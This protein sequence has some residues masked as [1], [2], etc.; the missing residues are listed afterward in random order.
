MAY[1]ETTYGSSKR[2][3]EGMAYNYNSP[4]LN[5]AMHW[6][7]TQPQVLQVP[8]WSSVAQ[9]PTVPPLR[10]E[11]CLLT[12]TQQPQEALVTI[13]GKEKARKPLDPP[14]IVKLE[15]LNRQDP[16][17]QFFTNPYIFSVVT[18]LK[19]DKNEPWGETGDKSLLGC[20]CSSLHRLKDLHN[21]EGGFFIWGDISLRM[22]G[23]FRLRFT[24]YE[25]QFGNDTAFQSLGSVDSDIFN[26]VASKDFRGLEE[27]TALTRSF[28]DQGV[29]LRLRKETKGLGKRHREESP[30]AAPY[31]KKR[32][33]SPPAGPSAYGA[34]HASIERYQAPDRNAT[35]LMPMAYPTYGYA[36]DQTNGWSNFSQTMPGAGA[37]HQPHPH[38][39]FFS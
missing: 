18:V 20:L 13:E 8:Q 34:P 11:T 27:S 1:N 16:H 39:Q 31:P 4:L 9:V 3:P 12:I 36:H 32:I 23:S 10:P 25:L 6:P 17:S 33:T 24:L 35:P 2:L 21:K 37:P 38:S 5:N 26:V 29:R 15:V 28:S 22:V 30:E 19:P 14:P 7:P